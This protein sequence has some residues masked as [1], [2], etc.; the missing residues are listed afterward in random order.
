MAR[1]PPPATSTR[2]MSQETFCYPGPYADYPTSQCG[3]YPKEEEAFTMSFP[4]TES[5]RGWSSPPG[6]AANRSVSGP[7]NASAPVMLHGPKDPSSNM[8]D[9]LRASLAITNQDI[10][11]PQAW[12]MDMALGLD[13]PS[14]YSTVDHNLEVDTNNTD[15][16]APKPELHIPAPYLPINYK[17][18]PPYPIPLDRSESGPIGTT[19]KTRMKTK[20]HSG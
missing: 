9:V 20:G 13:A 5:G 7:H 3:L 14:L 12:P 4:Q 19:G 18:I 6:S 11:M 2:I 1:F 17:G 8:V 10:P 15:I 16:M